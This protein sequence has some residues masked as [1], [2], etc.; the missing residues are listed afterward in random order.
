MRPLAIVGL[1]ALC[2]LG[3]ER[4]DYLQLTPDTVVLRQPNNEVWM[5]AKAMT[6]T[7]RQAAHARAAW[8]I[9]DPAIATV[10]ESGKVRPVKS[11]KTEVIATYKEVTASVP[12]E[13]I[14]VE[15]VEVTPTSLELVE[16][17]DAT[18]LKVKVLGPEG[19]V[20]TDRS[21]YYRAVDPK[22]VSLGK[23]A[24]YGLTVGSTTVEVQVDGVKASIPAVVKPEPKGAKK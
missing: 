15:K 1:A 18:E 16:G 6:H 20:L 4:V 3:C 11:G 23:N 5:Q 19:R 2:L 8:S 12:V 21:P 7:G 9:K 17:G 13:V 10:D 22:V 24:A 14:Y